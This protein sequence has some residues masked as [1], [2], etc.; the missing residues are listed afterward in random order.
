M[1]QEK[2]TVPIKIDAETFREFAVYDTLRRQKH[3]R[4]PA[5]FAAFFIAIAALAFTRS[6]TVRGAALLGGV[7]LAVGVGLPII[8]L[9]S[10][11]RSVRQRA[12][13]LDPR[14]IV[15]TVTLDDAGI[16]VQKGK[17]SAENTWGHLN[18]A[19]RLEHSVC[20]YADALHAFL[21]PGARGSAQSD[22][23]W[24]LVTRHM[25]AEKI[26]S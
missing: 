15:Y 18:A 5:V 26:H 13:R 20:L 11:F 23:L 16:A 25:P 3:W 7:L 17:Q 9:T 1:S 22:E 21:L 10:F 24:A 19:C 4:R 8:Y 12:R 6:G 14:E 2:Y